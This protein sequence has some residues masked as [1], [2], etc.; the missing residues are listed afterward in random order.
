MGYLI[1][2]DYKSLIQVDGLSQII[3][4]DYSL[5][6][7]AESAGQSEVITYLVQ[8]YDTAKE[9]TNT[10]LYTYGTTRNAKDRVYLDASPYSALSTYALN[11]LALVGG[12]VY[13]CTSAITVAEPWTIGHWSL[14]GAQ[15][16]MFYVKTPNA[17]WDYYTEYAA[18]T[19]VFD[20][21]KT[22]TSLIGNTG[23]KPSSNPAYW[24]SGTTYTVAGT[25][26]PTDT[27]KWIEGDNR[28]AQMVQCMVD[29]ILY[30]I[31]S[32]IPPRNIP[33]LRVKRY[34]DAIAFLK[35]AAK[36]DWITLAIAKIQPKSGMRTRWGSQ[37][38]KQ[39]NRY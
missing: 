37:L 8:K 1:R 31:H 14:L 28:N 39:N 18:G 22:Y 34:D 5:L 25:V 19:T 15:Y 29:V 10:T 26:L 9:F 6:S 27:S 11:S 2:Q 23:L 20:D 24:G 7:K 30:H 33:E 4:S 16:T 32:R 38:A 17:D 3:G 21:N 12:N 36:G 13:I 35:N